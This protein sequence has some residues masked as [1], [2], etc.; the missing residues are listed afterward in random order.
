M[1]IVSGIMCLASFICGCQPRSFHQSTPDLIGG[2][3]AKAGQFPATVR[4][5]RSCTAAL[6][7]ETHVLLAAHCLYRGPGEFNSYFFRVGGP[8]EVGFGV[9]AEVFQALP[10]AKF[11]VHESYRSHQEAAARANEAYLANPSGPL[12]AAEFRTLAP[13][14]QVLDLALLEFDSSV[15]SAL[16][17]SQV[18]R[19][20]L[21][22]VAPND[23]LIAGGYGCEG[24]APQDRTKERRLKFAQFSP[25]STW[26]LYYSAHADTGF[27]VCEGDSGGP[28]YRNGEVVG[29][30]SFRNDRADMRSM[31]LRLD[32]A[33]GAWLKQHLPAKAFVP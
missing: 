2:D 1:R 27:G 22:P 29:L 9:R 25:F 28:V 7:S 17:G 31:F 16:P 26:D 21:Q 8:V 33:A 11:W 32:G 4:I 23:A 19:I 12:P 15:V 6:V 5:H 14:L 18:A 30:N 24:D 13:P 3:E 10:L 20:S